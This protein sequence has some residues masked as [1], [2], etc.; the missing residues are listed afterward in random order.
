MAKPIGPKSMLIREAIAAN[1]DTGNTDLATIINFSERA[2]KAGITV[3][4]MDVAQQKQ[5]LKKP[6]ATKGVVA[7]PTPELTVIVVEPAPVAPAKKKPGRKPG[8]GKK[9]VLAPIAALPAPAAPAN[10][11]AVDLIDKVFD[12]AKETGGF[13]VLK[14]LVDRLAER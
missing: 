4:P 14:R 2:N 9:A 3:T 7:A 11:S 10:G 1:P 6:G 12:L 13:S 5:A 8:S